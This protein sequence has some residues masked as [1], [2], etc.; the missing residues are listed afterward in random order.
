[1]VGTTDSKTSCV[2]GGSVEMAMEGGKGT[3]ILYMGE[4]G[5]WKEVQL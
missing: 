2:E 1:M 3:F 5:R 4:D